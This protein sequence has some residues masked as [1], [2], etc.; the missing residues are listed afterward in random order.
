L[1]SGFAGF[2]VR[3]V[4]DGSNYEVF[5]RTAAYEQDGIEYVCPFSTATKPTTRE[6]KSRNKF[7]T[8]RVPFENFKPVLRTA[9]TD[10]SNVVVPPFQGKDVRYIG[11]RYRSASNPDQNKIQQ[12]E[13]VGFYIAL[14]Y[15]KVYRLQPEPEFVYLS[16]ARIPPV[17]RN[18][19]VRHD[20][21]RLLL[22]SST[23]GED[24]GDF[25]PLLDEKIL[26]GVT[27][28]ERS[29]EETYYKFRGEEVLKSS[30]LSYTIVRVAGYNESPSGEASTIDL[31]SVSHVS[32]REF[33]ALSQSLIQS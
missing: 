29:P 17:V 3:L 23:K 6:K 24:S 10:S 4:G 1:S 25:V 5:V 20:Q 7:I 21:R 31:R 30:G 26:K 16:D 22:D 19:M 8:A 13:N 32:W 11:F 18:G 2:I 9:K 27:S 28:S 14:S 15:V 33:L 12:G